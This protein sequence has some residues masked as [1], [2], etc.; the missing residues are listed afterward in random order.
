MAAVLLVGAVL[1]LQGGDTGAAQM[2][3]GAFS[4]AE[5]AP[6]EIATLVESEFTERY[7]NA[8]HRFSFM[9]PEGFTVRSFSADGGE[10]ILLE[11]GG[12]GLQIFITPFDEIGDITEERIRK[13]IPDMRIDGAQ[14][15]ELGTSGKGL[16][17]I[18][19]NAEWG[20]NSREV[21]FAFNGNLYQLSTYARLD[22]LLKAI[23]NT[24]K[25]E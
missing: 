4:A 10:S 22:M 18:S 21:W 13:D 23:L 7:E 1:F 2:P 6:A 15:V 5:T 17:F 11:R 3:A 16:A 25:F 12:D 24:W 8:T 20:G 19:D 9:Y 14:P